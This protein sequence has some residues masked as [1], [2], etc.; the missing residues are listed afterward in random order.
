MGDIVMALPA[1]SAL[2]RNFPHARISWLVRPEF[3]GLLD[4][5]PHLDQIIPFDRKELAKAW[6]APAAMSG[7]FS[8]IQQ[9]RRSEFDAVFDLQG[10]FRTA[11]ISLLT[12]CKKRFGMGDAREFAPLFYT[13]KVPPGPDCIHVVDYYLKIVKAA[14]AADITPQFVLPHNKTAEAS[15]R[16]LLADRGVNCQNYAVLIPGS[17]HEY[18]CWPPE[19]FAAIAGKVAADF[20]FDIIAVG[21]KG[22]KP[23]IEKLKAL[24]KVRIPDLA[25]LTSLSELIYLLRGA[26]A[27]VSNDTGPGHIA[28]VLDVPLAMMYGRS[29]PIR[30]FPY[31]TKDSVVA[32]EPF[33]R[34]LALNSFD[35]RHDIRAV[36][37]DQ[38]YT[39]LCR[40]IERF[41]R[42]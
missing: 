37:T 22:E 42:K 14:G 20:G 26:R 29:N 28:G 2:R 39:T 6:Y 16:K 3:A 12:G 34:G 1:L 25:G 33:S 13:D 27:V 32:V 9:L 35:P 7:L 18:K 5:H 11:A 40:Q 21:T 15:I 23:A 31:K 24:A 19:N 10:L 38:V 8:L 17:A 36:T 4:G 30:I 41:G